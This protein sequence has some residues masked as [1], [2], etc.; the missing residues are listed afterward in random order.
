MHI[1]TPRG[2]RPAP[3]ASFPCDAAMLGGDGITEP[4]ASTPTGGVTD[5]PRRVDVRRH[6]RG[7]FRRST[8]GQKGGMLFTP[9]GTSLRMSASRT[10]FV[11]FRALSR[12]HDMGVVRHRQR[13][14][15][16]TP[17]THRTQDAT[18]SGCA[19][20][21]TRVGVSVP[22]LRRDERTWS[23][24]ATCRR[25]PVPPRS[26]SLRAG[27]HAFPRLERM[28]GCFRTPWRRSDAPR[29]ARAGAG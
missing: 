14:S 5:E 26:L 28:P 22:R 27:S 10:A 18:E 8:C 9:T 13:T 16:G 25:D 29:S 21:L 24:S 15:I 7:C 6:R 2:T 23:R 4:Q 11:D 3:A 12:H 19:A 20:Q 1:T 17:R